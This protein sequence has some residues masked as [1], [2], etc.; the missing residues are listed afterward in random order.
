MPA[1]TETFE[2]YATVLGDDTLHEMSY[3]E[4]DILD[5][6]RLTNEIIAH[7]IKF[8]RK[9]AHMTETE[10]ADR[11]CRT[12]G[13]VR[14]VEAGRHSLTLTEFKEFADA[15][16]IDHLE[17]AKDIFRQVFRASHAFTILS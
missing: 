16:G 14:L 8:H 3:G 10:F 11:L 5:L 15:L 17:F 6:A 13:F 7:A 1:I 4:P 2:A 12:R 9:R